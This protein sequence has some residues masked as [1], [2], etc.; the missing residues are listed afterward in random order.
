MSY[1]QNEF[2]LYTVIARFMTMEK[3]GNVLKAYMEF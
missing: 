2:V 1:S 3:W